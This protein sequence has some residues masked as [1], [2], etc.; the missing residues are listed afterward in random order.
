MREIPFDAFV[1]FAIT[2]L[3]VIFILIGVAISRAIFEAERSVMH[4]AEE[5]LRRSASR[6][7]SRPGDEVVPAAGP[8]GR[9]DEPSP[10]E[11]AR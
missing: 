11:K 6:R 4:R 9:G 8:E 2:G 3:F 10:D 5:Y 1:V 7:Q